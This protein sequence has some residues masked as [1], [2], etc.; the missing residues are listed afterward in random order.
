MPDWLTAAETQARLNIR[1]Q[2]LYAYASRGRLEVKPDAEDPRRS[3]YR[4]AD[5]ARLQ[6]R[7]ARGRK[8][9]AVAEDAIAWGEPVLASTITTIFEGRLYYRGRD[10]VLLAQSESLER[11]ARLLRGGDGVRMKERPAEPAVTFG[12]ARARLFAVLAAHAAADAPA[13]GRAPLALAAEAAGL[14]D[15]AADAVAGRIVEGPIHVRFAEAWNTGPDGGDLIRRALVLLA[16]HELNASTFAARVAASTGASLA[17]AALAGLSALS[18]PLHGGMTAR[19]E[20]FIGEAGRVGAEAAVRAR[21]AQGLPVPGFGHPLYPAGDPRAEALLAA[22]SPPPAF[23]AVL[24][25][26]ERLTGERANVDF[27]LT[28]LSASLNLPK[29]AAFL[30]FAI[31][32]LAGWQAHALE[33]LA[34]GRLIRPRARYTGPQPVR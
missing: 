22:F 14:L 34:T 30:L 19:V 23:A 3:L 33:Q 26:A 17:A 10:A 31:A 7:K 27:P 5:V 28:A 12:D 21:I 16:D 6:E 2:T 13:R 8:A 4:A 15:A 32:R 29:G 9:S 1:P 25:A 20:A 11:V 24:S 18:G